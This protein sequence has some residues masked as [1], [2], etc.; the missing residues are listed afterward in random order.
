MTSALVSKPS[1]PVDKHPGTANKC[2][3]KGCT[4]RIIPAPNY[5]KTGPSKWRSTCTSPEHNEVWFY[6]K[7]WKAEKDSDYSTS[8]NECDIC[9]W[10]ICQHCGACHESGCSRNNYRTIRGVQ[11]DDVL[12]AY[13]EEEFPKLGDP[14]YANE[15]EQ[16][17]RNINQKIN[18]HKICR[19]NE[20]R[21]KKQEAL[22]GSLL[23]ACHQNS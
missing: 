15:H 8:Y 7:C 11:A 1:V 6:G 14:L 18:E 19:E 16:I 13:L 2:P 17:E 10:H 12:T 22:K 20:D 9:E 4:S 23:D 3:V 5:K 21:H